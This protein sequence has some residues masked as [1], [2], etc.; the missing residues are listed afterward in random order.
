M[1]AQMVREVAS[2]TSD[3]AGDGT[4]TATVLAESIYREGLKFVTSGAN[5]YRHPARHW[6]GRGS[7]RRAP[8]QDRQEGEGQGRDQ[9]GC[10][11]PSLGVAVIAGRGSEL[12]RT[13]RVR[14]RQ[15]IE[16]A[17]QHN[18]HSRRKWGPS[19]VSQQTAKNLFLWSSR[20]WTLQGLEAWFTLLLEVGWSK[21]RIL[22]VYLNI[23][24]FGDGVYGAEA[25]ARTFLWWWDLLQ[26]L[27]KQIFDTDIPLEAYHYN[28]WKQR[29]LREKC[30]WVTDFT[31]ETRLD[32][33]GWVVIDHHVTEVVRKNA[34]A[35]SRCEQ[36]RRTALL[37]T[38]PRES[39]LGSPELDRLVH[40]NDVADLFLDD[41]PN[42]AVATDY[43]NLVKIYQFWNL[44]RFELA[45]RL[46]NC[47]TIRCSK[48]WP[49]NDAWKIRWDSSGARVTSPNCARLSATWTPSLATIIWSSTG[50]WKNKPTPPV[51]VTLFRRGN[52]GFC[53]LS[54]P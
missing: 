16:K 47:S 37:R 24:E 42:F 1:G 49:R 36:V 10:I 54:Q 38:L 40:L 2:K 29:E 26:R 20:S 8:R 7:R 28:Q 5:P 17:V 45:A 15:A 31:F 52:L 43:A 44:H 14:D 21:K 35:H 39:G 33:P 19:T 11:S 30:A 3:A 48:S 6:Q 18:E 34:P 13:F 32:K 27:A 46:R 53:Q 41:D 12:H 51:L 4:T 25:A 23:V 22:E 50:C 9:A